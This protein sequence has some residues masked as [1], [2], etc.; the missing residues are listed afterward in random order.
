MSKIRIWTR[1]AHFNSLLAN[2]LLRKSVRGVSGLALQLQSVAL[3]CRLMSTLTF[4]GYIPVGST[5]EWLYQTADVI[6]LVLLFQLL[7]CVY[8]KFKGTYESENDQ[9]PVIP[10]ILACVSV[11]TKRSHV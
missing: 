10:T 2:I 5:G 6:A 7:F 9:W 1:V 11:E 8:Y 3:A 4:K